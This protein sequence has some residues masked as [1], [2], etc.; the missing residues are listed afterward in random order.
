MV[1]LKV[2]KDD[3]GYSRGKNIYMSL[4]DNIMKAEGEIF[5]STSKFNL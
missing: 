1:K 4:L 2:G 3:V 5:D